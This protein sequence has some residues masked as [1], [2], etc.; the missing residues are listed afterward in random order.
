MV[1]IRQI[2]IITLFLEVCFS[3]SA[4]AVELQE[5]YRGVRAVAMGNAFTAIADDADAIFYNP[6]GLALNN[7]MKLVLFNPKL[8]ISTDDLKAVAAI[9]Q[10]AKSFDADSVAKIF[11]KNLYVAGTIFP[12]IH[13]PYFVLGLY[14]GANLHFVTRNLTLPAFD[15]TYIVDY[16]LVTGF[17]F[18]SRGFSKKHFLRNGIGLKLLTRQGIDR[19]IP[20][21][22]LV[23]ADKAVL[24]SLKSAPTAGIGLSL[25]TQYEL[26]VS[27]RSDL[28]LG[29]SWLDVGDTN[30]GG[31][32]TAADKRPPKIKQNLTA[33]AALISYFSLNR[34][35][36]SRSNIKFAAEA[37][38]LT[39]TGKDPLLKLHAGMEIDIKGWFSVQLGW[40]QDDWTAGA[41]ASVW[42]FD[43]SAVTYSVEN[44]ALAFMNRERRY[45]VQ[46]TLEFD[47]LGEEFNTTRYRY[48]RMRPRE[49]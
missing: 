30:F 39:D 6:A 43:V 7:R 45:M 1:I 34:W 3:L 2:F 37:R 8:E 35:K 41:K 36:A 12:S 44:Q 17:G 31:R 23:T 18:E 21:S 20:I 48:R 11:G 22:T 13:F 32:L 33:G 46:L 10:I 9:K 27:V 14:A 4:H 40:S 29:S 16:G 47:M 38:H 49:Y 28:I 15:V 26:P 24:S 25:G 42:P 5:F 19:R